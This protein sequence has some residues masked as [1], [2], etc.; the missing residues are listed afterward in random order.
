VVTTSEDDIEKY[1]VH[2][3]FRTSF[4]ET[5]CTFQVMAF[6]VVTPCMDMGVAGYELL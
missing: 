4:Y 3:S 6:W 1:V 2:M 5:T